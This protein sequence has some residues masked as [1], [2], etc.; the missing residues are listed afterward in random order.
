MAL[1]VIELSD[2]HRHLLK[3]LAELIPDL[4]SDAPESLQRIFG[5]GL[6]ALTLQITNKAKTQQQD[7]L[8]AEL[9]DL[10]REMIEAENSPDSPG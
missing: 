8:V 5:L 1:E 10:A 9:G 2:K 7:D 3:R 6:I 4:D